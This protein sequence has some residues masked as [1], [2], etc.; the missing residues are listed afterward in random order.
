MYKQLKS[1]AIQLAISYFLCASNFSFS[2][3]SVTLHWR[4]VS[5]SLSPSSLH[6]FLLHMQTCLTRCASM[7][8][9]LGFASWPQLARS[10]LFSGLEVSLPLT[11]QV[12]RPLLLSLF[13]LSFFCLCL[14]SSKWTVD[15]EKWTESRKRRPVD[16]SFR[17]MLFS[18][19]SSSLPG[20]LQSFTSYWLCSPGSSLSSFSLLLCL[21]CDPI[22]D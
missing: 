1:T 19:S 6:I 13:S 9:V 5:L 7:A 20:W 16:P 21:A 2:T 14:S 22:C 8:C 11:S 17:F 3:V 15:K 18:P 12:T 10:T 4:V